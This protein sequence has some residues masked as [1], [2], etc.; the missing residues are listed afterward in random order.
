MRLRRFDALEAPLSGRNL[1]E[2]GAGTGKTWSIT[3]LYL[4][5]LLERRLLVEQ[6]LVVTYTRAATA[7]LQSR[8]RERLLGMQ[9]LLSGGQAEGAFERALLER[10]EDHEECATRIELALRSLDLAPIHTIH[11]YCQRMLEEHA[12]ACGTEF[13]TELL[14]DTTALEQE[15]LADFWRHHVAAAGPLFLS[16]LREV[17]KDTPERLAAGLLPCLRGAPVTLEPDVLPGA[18][19]DPLPPAWAVLRQGWREGA[20][21]MYA[22]MQEQKALRANV[23]K[24]ALTGRHFQQLDT[25]LLQADFP[26]WPD[27][28]TRKALEYFSP[29][30][31][32]RSTRKG[33][34]A[35]QHPLFGLCGACLDAL[36]QQEQ[37]F[38][39]R[40]LAL[41]R[42][43]VLEGREALQRR[44]QRESVIGYEDLLQMLHRALHA[45]RGEQLATALRARHPA[46]LIDEFQDTDPLQYGIFDRIYPRGGESCL[47]LV[48]DPKQSIYGFRGADVFSYLQARE[49]AEQGHSLETNWRSVPGLL[50]AVNSLFGGHP[51][52][53][54]LEEIAYHR[55][56]PCEDPPEPLQPRDRPPLQFALLPRDGDRPL[57]R[58]Q[59]RPLSAAHCAGEIVA[60]LRG[61]QE[62]KTRLDGRPLAG[63]DIAVLVHTHEQGRL[64]QEALRQRGI[65]SA[66]TSQES[67]FHSHE[68]QELERVLL[69]VAEPRDGGLLRT[70]LATDMLG[71]RGE[72]IARLDQEDARQTELLEQFLD[73]HACWRAEGTVAMLRRL[74]AQ[75]GVAGRLLRFPDG[76]RRLTNLLHLAELLQA[77]LHR[78][79]P[80]SLLAW[81]A[82]QRQTARRDPEEAQLRLESDEGLV[83]ILTIHKSKGLEFPVVFCP[84]F[85][86]ATARPD[87]ELAICHEPGRG[88]V[89]DLGSSAWDRRRQQALREAQSEQLRLL[90]V[91]LTR[92]ARYCVAY[93]GV[94]NQCLDGAGSWLLFPGR[95]EDPGVLAGWLGQQDDAALL[96][97]LEELPE[98]SGGTIGVRQLPAAPGENHLD[99]PRPAADRL[100]ARAPMPAPALPWRLTSFSALL[101]EQP[102]EL[103]DHDAGVLQ[104]TAAEGAAGGIH[105]F[106]RGPV[107]GSCLHAILEQADFAADAAGLAPLVEHSLLAWGIDGQWRDLVAGHLEQVLATPLEEGG[108]RLRELGPGERLPELPFSYSCDC[109]DPPSLVQAL[110]QE[111]RQR[112]P[113]LARAASQLE[114]PRIRGYMKGFID[115]VFRWQGRYWLLDYKSNW[116]GPDAGAY[117]PP[118]LELAIAEEHYYLQYLIY[119]VALHRYLQRRLP[120]YEYG[121]HFGGVYYLFLRGMDPAR[122]G[123][124]VWRDRPSPGL[125]GALDELLGAHHA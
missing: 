123:H 24:P 32:M 22:L 63:Q 27:G 12:F 2:A 47:Y 97:A 110:Q 30:K 70:A 65:A 95:G 38:S 9:V 48:G 36:G 113:R 5:L 52:P 75:H 34:E 35:P 122:P 78:S 77:Q 88:R 31:L 104:P 109:P 11:G 118:A 73:Y 37:V 86:S 53:F 45:E 71:W 3:S 116:L 98:R 57:S 6:V 100:R 55:L 101:R 121:R 7:E 44:K 21:Q 25:W 17:K 125:I 102:P 23:Y 85:W 14:A 16:W 84:F 67:V 54:L 117:E 19:A 15:L 28:D 93:W 83:R 111:Y 76:E 120:E 56:E 41:R 51:A 74:M 107:A 124:A 91:A 59:A 82:E 26:T 81:L 50:Q 8:I 99:Q 112:A 94:V 66:M 29:D 92:A 96:A 79:T 68:A 13:G 58:E 114:L 72:E 64:V 46:A 4:R 69:A 89:L 108:P 33:Q 39:T 105:A 87:A 18:D 62:G 1:V 42:R 40:L 43:L 10:L 80:S 90:Y 103:P 106:P 60:L 61:A 20:A 115:L 119:S 49:Q